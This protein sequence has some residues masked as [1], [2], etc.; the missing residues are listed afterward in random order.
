MSDSPAVQFVLKKMAQ[1]GLSRRA[2][3]KRAAALGLSVPAFA[4]LLAA[5]GDDDDDVDEPADDPA[6]QPTPEPEE[7]DDEDDEDDEEEE[8]PEPDDDEDEDDEDDVAD[9]V[10]DRRFDKLVVALAGDLVS[11]DLMWGTPTINR[12]LMGHVIEYLFTMS[13]GNEYIPDL[14]EVF[15]VSED[16]MSF[17]IPLRQG[18]P[19]HNGKEMTSEDVIASLGRWERMTQRG[20]SLMETNTRLEAADDYTIELEFSEPN[21]GLLFGLGHYGGLA[22]IFP[23]EVVEKYYNEAEDEDE[24]ITDAADV[25]G[26]GPYVHYEWIA[27]RSVV[28][29]R[30]E[31]YAMRDEPVDGRGGARHAYATEIEFIPVPDATTRLN[32]LI[33]GEYHISY[34]VAPA[35]FQQVESDQNLES[36]II[37][38]GSKVVAVFNKQRGPFTDVRLR[39]AALAASNCDEVMT[40]AVDD[41]EFY[42]VFASL[43]GPEW[44]FWYTEVGEE[45]FNQADVE[46]A[47]E[48]I[49]ETDYDGEVLRWIT[50]R[51][52]DYMYRS[53]LVAQQ[54]WGEAGLN[55]EL[56]VSDWPTVITNRS[57]PEV[58]EIFSTGIGFAGDPLGTSAYTNN[59]PG[60]TPEGRITAAYEELIREA[61][62]DVRKSLWEDLQ[63]AFYEEVPYVQFGERYTL[64]ATRS[65]V[66]GFTNRPDFFVWNIWLEG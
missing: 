46:R 24:Q 18:V 51:D 6:D 38:P 1:D 25:I 40:G 47:R 39:Q 14:A 27:D 4:T 62:P 9:D 57:D 29:R 65:E 3:V 61:D 52:F 28:F 21:G 26:T 50:T 11:A 16:G 37:R 32:G 66:N 45:Y 49:A 59:W 7:E 31:D 22:G 41:A 44:E 13:E 64:R 42:G 56:V 15:E 34:D 2:F 36:Y 60:W 19:F 35:Q 10:D 30:F 20:A 63:L 48:L 23:S 8:T 43:A 54:Q 55:I 58:Y 53:A 12:D 5:C 17:T 33:A